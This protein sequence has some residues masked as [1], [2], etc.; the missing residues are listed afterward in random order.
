MNLIEKVVIKDGVNADTTVN[1]NLYTGQVAEIN[2]ALGGISGL[3][4]VATYNINSGKPQFVWSG[5]GNNELWVYTNGIG[6][7]SS[8]VNTIESDQSIRLLG[9]T[10][11]SVYSQTIFDNNKILVVNNAS[12]F[13]IVSLNDLGNGESLWVQ[14]FRNID[15]QVSKIMAGSE[16]YFTIK[17]GELVLV[18]S[19]GAGTNP[20]I[21]IVSTQSMDYRNLTRTSSSPITL[22]DSTFEDNLPISYV[23]TGTSKVLNITSFTKTGRYVRIIGHLDQGHTTMVNLPIGHSF[24][25][26]AGNSLSFSGSKTLILVSAT[27]W[28]FF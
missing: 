3:R 2:A 17:P 12:Q 27:E 13:I 1:I 16:F 6:V 24:I 10:G 8:G 22:L 19:N 25:A 11:N 15:I 14:N 7:K 28:V 20:T 9:Y 4:G 26:T 5:V 18:K 23:F 21:T